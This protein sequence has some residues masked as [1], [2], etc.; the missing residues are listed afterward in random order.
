M[1]LLMEYGRK[2]SLSS[3]NPAVRHCYQDSINFPGTPY[4]NV[5]NASVS[6]TQISLGISLYTVRHVRF[7]IGHLYLYRATDMPHPCHWTLFKATHP[8]IRPS[9]QPIPLHRHQP[10]FPHSPYL[11]VLSCGIPPSIPEQAI[12][13]ALSSPSPSSVA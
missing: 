4:L 10:F 1:F 3:L 9:P 5:H 12:S 2:R 6:R 7:I 8:V 11:L 13:M